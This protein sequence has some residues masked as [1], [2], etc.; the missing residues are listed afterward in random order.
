MTELRNQTL[1]NIINAP[2]V[3]Q[4][5]EIIDASI[6]TLKNNSTHDFI[7]IR[8]LSKLETLMIEMKSSEV[9]KNKIKNLNEAIRCINK[10]ELNKIKSDN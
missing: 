9:T 3:I 1:E 4:V 7:I 5:E 6:K 8:F 2:N 10:H